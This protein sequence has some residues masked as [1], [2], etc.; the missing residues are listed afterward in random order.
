MPPAPSLEIKT[1]NPASLVV[2]LQ[3]PPSPVGDSSRSS[4]LSSE[5][6]ATYSCSISFKQRYGILQKVHLPGRLTFGKGKLGSGRSVGLIRTK[7][8]SERSNH[9]SSLHNRTGGQTARLA[10]RSILP[11][12]RAVFQ[13]SGCR[14]RLQ[15]THTIHTG[16]Q[17]GSAEEGILAPVQQFCPPGFV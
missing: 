16:L 10:M 15:A 1:I 13:R 3:S 17:T 2:S 12:L 9:S 6:P 5:T 14:P 4:T 11:N 8:S 7:P